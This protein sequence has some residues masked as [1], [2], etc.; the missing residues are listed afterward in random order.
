MAMGERVEGQGRGIEGGEGDE[1]YEE[2]GGKGDRRWGE[3]RGEAGRMGEGR[4]GG[5]RRRR[6]GGGTSR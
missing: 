3:G 5:K 6:G 2:G 4:E 1:G